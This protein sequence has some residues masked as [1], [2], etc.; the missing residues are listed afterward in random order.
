[1]AAEEIPLEGGNVTS[2]VVRVGDTVRRPCKAGSELAHAVL[3]HLEN[4]GFRHAPRFLGIDDQGR[5]ILS[6]VPGHTIWPHE[7]ER[8]VDGRVLDPIGA[9]VRAFH[10]AMASFPSPDGGGSGS[11]V[12][13]GDLAPWNVVVGDDG[14]WTLI[15]WD[16]VAPGKPAWELAYVLHTFVPLWPNTPFADDD[17]EVV[18]RIER[19]GAAYG[20]DADFLDD[21]LRLVPEKCRWLADAT[22]RFARE[23]DAAFQTMVDDGHPQVWREGADHV[24]GRLPR[25]LDR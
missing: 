18:R 23:G 5:E 15:D 21:A 24:A 11:L 8:L 17:A 7:M 19:L 25:W 9:L 2:G 4:V 10:D 14:T 20:A 13:H 16:G 6:F 3:R 1:M 22:E 12:L